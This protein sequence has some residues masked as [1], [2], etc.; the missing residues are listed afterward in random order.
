MKTY[1]SSGMMSRLFLQLGLVIAAQSANAQDIKHHHLERMDRPRKLRRHRGLRQ[2]CQIQD[3]Q[4]YSA[5]FFYDS[6][7]PVPGTSSGFVNGRKIL[8]HRHPE[9]QRNDRFSKHQARS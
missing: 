8:C 4:I 6:A 3:Y 2:E 9:Q 7:N 1:P 5:L